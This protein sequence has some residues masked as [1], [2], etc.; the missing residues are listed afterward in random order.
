MY[1]LGFINLPSKQ[2]LYN[3]SHF[4]RSSCGIQTDTLKHLIQEVKAKGLYD[5]EWKSYVGLLE[6]EVKIKEDL[7][8][9]IQVNSL[10]T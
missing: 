4:T 7:V 1:D 5:E 8:Y 10:V 9:N 2:T 3:F 6:D